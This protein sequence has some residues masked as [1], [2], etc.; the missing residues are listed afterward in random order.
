M[1]L[2][3][4][5]SPL[6][7]KTQAAYAR[8][9]APWTFDAEAFLRTVR[10]IADTGAASVPSFDH[11]VGDPV[12]DGIRVLPTHR[13]VLVEGNYLFLDQP[14]WS[15]LRGLMHDTWFVDVDLGV[16]MQRVLTRQTGS[17]R[18]AEVAAARIAGNDRP[19]GEAVI[20]SRHV[21][22]V[23]VPSDVPFRGGGSDSSNGRGGVGA[24]G[25]AA[26]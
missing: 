12:P 21:G 7:P 3:I 2:N 13:I 16:A 24:T 17:G 5:I 6:S 22:R 18:S 19:N 25:E 9:G 10:T 1:T 15:E 20:A 8:R 4:R 26:Q 23:L 14:P 11:G